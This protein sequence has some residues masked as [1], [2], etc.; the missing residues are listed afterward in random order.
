LDLFDLDEQFSS[1]KHRLAQLTNKC[2]DKDLEYFVCEA[3]EILGIADEIRNA[4]LPSNA[5][6]NINKDTFN[7]V[8]ANRVLE[9]IL[10]KLIDWKKLD[11]EAPGEG[12]P[13]GMG[14]GG[15]EGS[16]E[17]GQGGDSQ[18]FVMQSEPSPKH[19][20]GQR[21]GEQELD[22]DD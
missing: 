19:A 5:G 21:G 3:G 1:E 10:R 17:Y 22:L 12:G 16:G 11:R 2:T 14:M 4:P 18:M 7:K 6:P 20:L 9:F 8:T 15:M 13:G